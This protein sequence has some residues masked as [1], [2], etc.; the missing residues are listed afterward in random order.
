MIQGEQI[1]LAEMLEDP[2]IGF[3]SQRQQAAESQEESKGGEDGRDELVDVSHRGTLLSLLMC[4]DDSLLMQM[5]GLLTVLTDASFITPE[6]KVQVPELFPN[7]SSGMASQERP[8][9]QA[10]TSLESS[11]ISTLTS[12]MPFRNFTLRLFSRLLLLR[13]T[14][15]LSD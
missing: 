10:A 1:G 4:K 8:P 11:F 3:Y 2:S 9:S 14:P 5:A 6:L 15:A 13:Q 12:E 7:S